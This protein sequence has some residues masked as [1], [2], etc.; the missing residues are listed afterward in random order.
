MDRKVGTTTKARDLHV[1]WGICCM[2][3]MPGHLDW[4]KGS[5]FGQQMRKVPTFNMDEGLIC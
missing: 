1:S 2:E 5:S 4:M 3:F